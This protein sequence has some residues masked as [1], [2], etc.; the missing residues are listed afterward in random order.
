MVAFLFVGTE[1]V[2][3]HAATGLKIYDYSTKK[4]SSYTGKQI[5][6][7]ING[8]KIT[9]DN[10]PGGIIVDG[11]AL[12]SYTDIFAASTINADCV[13]KKSKGTISISLY[14]TTIVMTI[15]SKKAIV[16]GK[17]VNM[18]VAPMKIKYVD[19]NIIKFLVPSRF[20]SEN[21]GL[22]YTWYSDKNTIAI[23]K[24]LISLSYNTGK[25][26]V[27]KGTMGNVSVDGTNINLGNMPSVILNDTAMLRAKKVFAGPEIGADYQYN[28]TDKTITLSKNG[29]VLI[30]KIASPVA[31]V[32][33]NPMVLDSAPI[34]IK[35]YDNN[36]SYVMVP[37][38]FTASCLG[39]NYTWDKAKKTSMITSRKEDGNSSSGGSQNNNGGAGSSDTTTSPELGDTGVINETGQILN[40]WQ[41]VDG[42]ASK[43][44]DL[45]ELNKE[46][47]TSGYSGFIY[48]VTRDYN[49]I[50]LNAESFVFYSS[51][52]YGKVTST[53][54]EHKLT[55][56][57]ANLSCT[58]QIY[59]MYGNVSNVV[60]TIHTSNKVDDMSTIIDFDILPDNIS[61]D[62][63]LSQDG[64]SLYVTIYLNGLTSVVL[65]NNSSGDYI[66]L[67]GLA[68]L[69]PVITEE[70]GFLYLDLPYTAN[71]IGDIYTQII[72]AKYVNLLYTPGFSDKTRILLQLD[73][74][75]E[76]YTSEDENKYTLY[77]LSPQTGN[78]PGTPTTDTP[79]SDTPTSDLPTSDIPFVTDKSNY[80]ITIPR[81][82]GVSNGQ[83][84]NT[85]YYSIN[86]FAI[87]IAGD[88]T[89][90]YNN[91]PA[92]FNYNVIQDVSVFL[93][94]NNETEILFSTSRLQGYEVAA[95]DKNI[96]VNIGEP[97]DIYKNIVVL[98][99]GHGGPANG[100]HYFGTDEKDINLKILYEI[101]KKYFDSNTSKLKV[102]YTRTTD[103]DMSLADRAGFANKIG[104][105]LFVSLHMNA[106]TAASAYGTEVYYSENNNK[107][108]A[109]GLNSKML[110]TLLLNNLTNSLGTD[111]RGA[112]SEK[113]TVVHRNTVPAIL[114][115]LGFLSNKNDFALI[116]DPVFQDNAARIIYE[117]LCQVFELYPTGR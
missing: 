66:T 29:N 48:A 104:A 45:H 99:C 61:Y 31:S 42:R 5:Q 97:R 73:A 57:T 14:G 15:N 79:T 50:K 90:F 58:D 107:V 87:K 114:I 6:V 94:S 43:S 112:K 102:Y 16:N 56:N 93:N 117:T 101:G 2:T 25:K 67:T 59:Q 37:G 81:P 71:T 103:V 70:A 80:E 4:E 96:Y 3:A 72:G 39:Y 53:Y 111:N 92:T 11:I 64:L 9:A 108:N 113:Y 19:S 78:Q 100:A 18:P 26:F 7:T 12:V 40:Q 35:N 20:V 75:Y 105:D 24:N 27:Y 88:Y 32:N 8:T 60:N 68:A 86:R 30:M 83:I 110:A 46:V 74:G 36:T 51:A 85:D 33:G 62:L 95:D 91:N 116:S 52:P 109:A 84:T 28:E 115:E 41:A 22:G 82:N 65:G 17:S 47:V 76:Y 106:S 63:S 54:S 21:L 34:L 69:K 77:L 1:A 38:G 89:A 44:S 49:N 55:I 98:D 23:Q 13:Y 10:T